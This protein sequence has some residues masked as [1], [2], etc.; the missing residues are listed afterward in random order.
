MDLIINRLSR[1]EKIW[2]IDMKKSDDSMTALHLTALNNHTQ[3][4]EKLIRLDRIDPNTKC[5]NSQT[6][7]HFAVARLN[8]EA[9]EKLVELGVERSPSRIIDLNLQDQDGH[10]PLH[11]LLVAF[12]IA[13]VW[14]ASK[15]GLGG[16]NQVF[17]GLKL[18][19]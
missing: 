7:L 12:S 8:F 16:T 15:S 5:W 14:S 13:N 18:M 1:M 9:C 17:I 11:V 3:M 4:L 10:T 19:I 6:A 2:L